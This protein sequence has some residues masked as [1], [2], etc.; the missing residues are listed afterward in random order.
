LTDSD[1]NVLGVSGRLC[2]S[3]AEGVMYCADPVE[4][5][6]AG[7]TI[8]APPPPGAPDAAVV[9]PIVEAGPL[10]AGV[11]EVT[12]GA[13]GG[14]FGI[15]SVVIEVPPGALDHD[16]TISIA[17]IAQPPA[18]AV[19]QAYEIGPTGTQFR[20]P[21]LLTFS[22]DDVDLDASPASALSVSTIVGGAWQ[23]VS[24][25]IMDPYAHTIGGTTTHLSPYALASAGAAV[26][27]GDG[28]SGTATNTPRDAGRDANFIPDATVDAGATADASTAPPC[29]TAQASLVSWWTG[30]GD[31]TDLTGLNTLTTTGGQ[32]TFVTG[33]VGQAMQLQNNAYLCGTALG[34]PIG[35]QA[36]T[37]E[38]WVLPQAA[39][40]QNNALVFGYGTWGTAQGTALLQIDQTAN[41][42]TLAFNPWIA[43]AVTGGNVAPNAWTH[44]AVTVTQGGPA[45][46]YVNGQVTGQGAI[47]LNTPSN[48]LTACIGGFPNPPDGIAEWFTGAVD[49]ISVYA[50]ALTNTDIQAI[51][52]AGSAGKCK[53]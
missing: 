30:D 10:E 33:K 25:P 4:V 24:S 19:G 2:A 46:L 11:D 18:G 21:I 53:Q 35:G 23:A 50:A 49:E 8:I 6:D 39:R 36:R 27:A 26:A 34:L 37:I 40:A 32:I 16:V 17:P 44:V 47:T 5:S 28:S 38:A 20:I 12:I 7:S 48:N 29:V 45:V 13:G 9:E 31:T 52:S 41:T 22:Y 42:N 14:T 51:Y 1:C 43:P 3:D 15:G